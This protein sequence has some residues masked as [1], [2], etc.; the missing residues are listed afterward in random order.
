L[1]EIEKDDYEF[2]VKQAEAL[3]N[4]T[5]ARLGTL[6]RPD[7][8]I[9]PEET[10]I[11]RRSAADLREANFVFETTEALAKEGVLSRIDYERA[12]VRRQGAE[13]AYQ[14]ALEEVM[15]LRAQLTERRAQLAL[16][17]Q[18]LGDCV[19]RAAFDGAVTERIASLGEYLPVNA[20]VVTM[21]RQHPL[22]LRLEV[23]ERDAGKVRIGQRIDVHLEGAASGHS[24]RVVR[25]SPAI[26]AQNRSLLV[27]GEIPNENGLLRPGTF[28]EGV[29]TVN[30]QARGI[31][32]PRDA[33]LSFA[34]IERVFIVADGGLQDR[35]IRTGRRLPEERIEVVEGLE[36]GLAVVRQATDRM[37]S[38]QKVAVR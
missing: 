15:Q 16:A 12:A 36:P 37:T 22:R 9:T 11:V 24:G 32:I 26:E 20:P 2:Y 8:E 35:V 10:A 14:A 34:G 33:L 38:G 1:A 7:D 23:P 6:D 3:V 5:R 30:P 31:L 18:N 25:L 27:E 4:Q 21:V 17:R 13:A 28:A 19:I 29:I